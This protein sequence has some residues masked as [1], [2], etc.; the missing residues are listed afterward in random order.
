MEDN[1][2][3]IQFVLI[4]ITVSVY[5]YKNYNLSLSIKNL[6]SKI[7][8]EREKK[9]EYTQ[10]KTNK[11]KEDVINSKSIKSSSQYKVNKLSNSVELSNN[12]ESSNSDDEGFIIVREP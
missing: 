10:I 1:N 5:I 11:Y 3:Y 2:Y 9:K 6:L 4:S 12:S 7:N 8:K